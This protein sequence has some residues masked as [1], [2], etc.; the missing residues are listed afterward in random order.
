LNCIEEDE[1]NRIMIE[2]H[3]GT[4]LFSYVF[5]KVIACMEFQIFVGKK[6]IQNL[7]IKPIAVDGP[8]QQWGLDFIG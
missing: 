4:S 5:S 8:F 7:R 1:P 6:K 2:L 3:K